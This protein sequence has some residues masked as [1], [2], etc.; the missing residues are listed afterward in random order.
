MNRRLF[1]ERIAALV[2][3]G[4]AIPPVQAAT[5]R[6]IELQ[7]SPVAGF[8]YHRGESVWSELQVGEGVMLVREPD[9]AFDPRAVRIDWR[10]NKLGYVPRIDNAAICHLLDNG[11]AVSAEIVSLRMSDNPWDRI[12]FAVYLAT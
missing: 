10:G 1:I 9:N 11:Q 2:G 6:R 4:V 7:R 3:L 12:E 8:Q 5:S